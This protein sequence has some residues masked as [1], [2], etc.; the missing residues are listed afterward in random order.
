[1]CIVPD[2][3]QCHEARRLIS[4]EIHQCGIPR[5]NSTGSSLDFAA[6]DPGFIHKGSLVATDRCTA[7]DG[8][9][10]LFGNSSEP[11]RQVHTIDASV[12]LETND[13]TRRLG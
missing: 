7:H 1:M 12:T 5:K 9:D 6:F 13:K 3:T 11:Y 8:V 2:T 4:E 10:V